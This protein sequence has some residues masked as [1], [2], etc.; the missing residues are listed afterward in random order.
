MQIEHLCDRGDLP[1]EEPV[2]GNF[3]IGHKERKLML[4]QPEPSE[5]TEALETLPGRG[6]IRMGEDFGWDYPDA[7]ALATECVLN[8]IHTGDMLL[9]RGRTILRE[10]G[11]TETSANV[12]AILRGAGTPLPPYVIGDRLLVTRGAVTGLLDSLER[13]GLVRRLPHPSDR[14]MLLVDLTSTAHQLLSELLPRVHR[15]ERAWMSCLTSEEQNMLV[16]LTG[17]IQSYL[18]TEHADEAGTGD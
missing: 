7:S 15:E 17:K 12:L 4:D 2:I 10:Y 5:P 8:L 6:A 9:R 11:L 13:R 14:R 18:G 1:G 3:R 16:E